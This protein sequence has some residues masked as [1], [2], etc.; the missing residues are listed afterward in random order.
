MEKKNKETLDDII[1]ELIDLLKY[2][3]PRP[4]FRFST[5]GRCCELQSI[6]VS[7]NKTII[8]MLYYA[9]PK[10]IQGGWVRIAPQTFIRHSDTDETLPLLEAV[11][12]PL[13]PE[14]HHFKN[15]DETLAFQLIFPAI[16]KSWIKIDLI[17]KEPGDSSYF[18]FYGIELNPFRD[19]II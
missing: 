12:I 6:D 8:N 5:C 11:N 2:P 7:D 15:A 17:E 4:T 9:Q 16:P 18:N 1:D 10:F 3:L 14:K 13:S 19:K